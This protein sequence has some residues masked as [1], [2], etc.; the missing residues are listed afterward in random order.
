ME[1]DLDRMCS[2][3]GR[4]ML[5]SLRS[6]SKMARPDLNLKVG[7]RASRNRTRIECALQWAELS[8]RV[9]AT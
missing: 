4:V 7:V 6:G 1:R 5:Q 3:M 8:C 2:I 9:H